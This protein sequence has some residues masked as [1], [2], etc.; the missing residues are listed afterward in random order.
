MEARPAG[1]NTKQLVMATGLTRSQVRRG[2][3]Y[4]RRVLAAQHK[5]P[6]IWT[7]MD[8]YRLGPDEPD[9]IAYE[10]A[11]FRT[12]LTRISR[13]IT[14]T[15]APHL[16]TAPADSWILLVH[17]QITGVKASLE[18]LAQYEKR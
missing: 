8:G 14:A 10:R 4:L 5:T 6:L 18:M 7:R 2:L 3:V 11:Q 12:E 17:Q 13:F 1:L 15:I 9:L 16:D